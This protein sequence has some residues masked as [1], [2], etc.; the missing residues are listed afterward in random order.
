LALFIKFFTA[1]AHPADLF[2]RIAYHEGVVGDI[3]CDNRI[4]ADEGDPIA[5]FFRRIISH[6]EQVFRQAMK[7][8]KKGVRFYFDGPPN[9]GKHLPG[10]RAHQV[11]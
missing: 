4:G 7:I 3:F 5:L 11:V 10:K 8:I 9:R 6:E 2:R 1:L